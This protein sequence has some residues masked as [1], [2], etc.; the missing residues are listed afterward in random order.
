MEKVVAI[1]VAAG[2]SKRMKSQINKPFLKING[3]TVIRRTVQQ[4]LKTN[5]I[6]SL[7]I[8][9]HSREIEMMQEHLQDLAP[10]AEQAIHICIGGKS[11]QESVY[12]GLLEIENSVLYRESP[13]LI[14]LV[15][16][17]ARCLIQ[18]KE[19][20]SCARLIAQ[21]AQSGKEIGVGVGIPV[22]DTIHMINQEQYVVNTPN[23]SSLVAIQTPQGAMFKTLLAAYERA[24]KNHFKATDDIS[25]LQYAGIPV[26]ICPGDNTNI[27]ITNP[28]DIHIAEKLLNNLNI[29]NR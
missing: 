17:G 4:F 19:I 12:N 25:V 23:R 8:V 21:A 3:E 14:C 1:I 24:R 28:Q 2:L 7:Y 26:Q 15:H 27:K 16:D 10:K 22:T 9:V 20:I 11:R 6:S 5:I 13:D 29:Q 18:S